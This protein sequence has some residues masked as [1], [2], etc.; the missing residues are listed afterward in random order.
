MIRQLSMVC[1]FVVLL[2][3]LTTTQAQKTWPA[4]TIVERTTYYD[5]KGDALSVS[6]STR[7]NSASGDWR[8]VGNFGGYELAT[9]SRRG[10]GVY[11]SSSR[12]GL[13]LKDSDHAPGCPLTTAE[14][15]TAIPS[16]SALKWFWV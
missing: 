12:I 13:L 5:I 3:S 11:K 16:L 1:T 15:L 10:K 8:S 7:Y 9:V 14:E 6:T 2:L 4:F